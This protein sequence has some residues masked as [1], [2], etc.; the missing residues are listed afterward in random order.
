MSVYLSVS[1]YIQPIVCVESFLFLLSCVSVNTDNA[2]R[3]VTAV[4]CVLVVCWLV[5][6]L[7]VCDACAGVLP[8]RCAQVLGILAQAEPVAVALTRWCRLTPLVTVVCHVTLI[9]PCCLP[10]A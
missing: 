2:N 3:I 7:C 10:Q 6:W 1:V 5:G 9:W 4:T 8:I